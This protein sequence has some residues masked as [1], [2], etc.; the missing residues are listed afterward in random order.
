MS[1]FTAFNGA[2]KPVEATIQVADQARP[3]SAGKANNGQASMASSAVKSEPA[4]APEPQKDTWSAPAPDR[5]SHYQR[6]SSYAEADNPHK[7]KRSDTDEIRRDPPPPAQQDRSPLEVT[8]QPA[9]SEPRMAYE[10]RGRDYRRFAEDHLPR[11]DRWYASQNRNSQ[12]GYEHQPSQQ[13]SQQ[14]Q[15]APSS[16]TPP[17]HTHSDDPSSGPNRREHGYSQMDEESESSPEADDHSGSVHATSPYGERRE[18]G[19]IL[20]DQE[21]KRKRNFSNRTKTGCMT[22]R[23]RKKKCD[24]LKP[25]CELPLL[26]ADPGYPWS[27]L[28]RP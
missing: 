7:R 18:N 22:C 21:K 8:A 2:E 3:A 17:V 12:S 16:R 27:S 20:V 6:R 23:K 28:L 11:S 26:A 25:E 14:S 9:H 15:P 19:V 1:A 13:R 5:P 24:E 10:N 4:K